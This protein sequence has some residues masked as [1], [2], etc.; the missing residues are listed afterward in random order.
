MSWQSGHWHVGAGAKQQSSGRKA[1]VRVTLRCVLAAVGLSALLVTG[2]QITSGSGART[3]DKPSAP[4]E[5]RHDLDP[6]TSRFPV[7]GHPLAASWVTWNNSSRGVPGQTAYWIDAV[8][9][10]EPS[11]TAALVAQ[12]QPSDQGKQP[13]VQDILRSD[14]PAGPFL[15]GTALD[16]A[17]STSVWRGVTYLDQQ[18]NQLVIGAIDD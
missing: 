10:L 8:I 17:F 13:H 4:T 16:H 7:A 1:D 6:L 5:I 18:D 9:T 2:C 3:E 12:Y 15:T 11:K 14:V